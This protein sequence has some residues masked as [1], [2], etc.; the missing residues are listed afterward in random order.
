VYPTLYI[1]ESTFSTRGILS[2]GHR[3]LFLGS[4]LLAIYINQ[5]PWRRGGG[6]CVVGAK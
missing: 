4:F 6:V 3:K 2:L 5:V 1:D